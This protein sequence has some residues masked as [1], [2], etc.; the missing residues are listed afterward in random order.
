MNIC[1]VIMHWRT[2]RTCYLCLYL[3]LYLSFE[4]PFVY[5]IIK[6]YFHVYLPRLTSV[7]P[8]CQQSRTKFSQRNTSYISG[9]RFDFCAVYF[10]NMCLLCAFSHESVYRYLC[11][12]DVAVCAVLYA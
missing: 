5:I 1:G 10:D 8:T 7:L 2:G 4:Q 6:F 12:P 9:K 11:R 3:Y